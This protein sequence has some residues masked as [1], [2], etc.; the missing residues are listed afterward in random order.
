MYE[1]GKEGAKITRLYLTL[2]SHT[3]LVAHAYFTDPTL[4]GENDL[5]FSHEE[6]RCSV[7]EANSMASA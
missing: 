3:K 2:F 5:L 4:Q 7:Q 1:R 6:H